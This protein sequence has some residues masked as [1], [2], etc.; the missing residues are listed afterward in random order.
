MK[1][2]NDRLAVHWSVFR[3]MMDM[4][5]LAANWMMEISEVIRDTNS[6]ERL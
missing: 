1:K 6:P 5:S 2:S 3:N 4:V